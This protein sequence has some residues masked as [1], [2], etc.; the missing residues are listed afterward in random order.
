MIQIEN[1]IIESDIVL[2]PMAGYTDSPYRRIA[3]R[4][5]ASLVFTEL[6]SADGIVRFGKKTMEL[7]KFTQMERPIG[8]QIFGKNPETMIEAAKIVE[9]LDPDLIDINFGCSVRR[10]IKNGAGAALLDNPILL[11]KIAEGIV[12]SVKVPV[13][14]KIR[15]GS[16][17]NNK[18]YIQI[19]N[20]LEDSGISLISVHGRTRKQRFSG[21][22]DWNIIKKIKENSTVPIIGN[23][24]IM[25][26]HDALQKQKLSGCNAVMIGR[27]A[28]GNPWIFSGYLPNY[29]E[30]VEQIKEHLRLMTDFYGEKGIILMRKHMVKYIR[31]MKNS[32]KIRSLV[33]N[34][35]SEEEIYSILESIID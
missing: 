30:I 23:G 2:A 5:G 29:R 31:N 4:H 17:E 25:S 12:K 13:S 10:V 15:I 11:K 6:I 33:V 24:D 27:G 35:N 28:I 18:N 3:R 14:A 7:L 26:Y 22:A 32:A 8:I 1:L 19:L 21:N 16:D 20:M 34:S 9:E